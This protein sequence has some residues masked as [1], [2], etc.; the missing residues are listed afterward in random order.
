MRK[1]LFAI[2]FVVF[3]ANAADPTTADLDALRQ[4]A[5]RGDADAQY[6]F[7]ILYEFGF[8]F[9]DNKT[10]AYVWYSRAAE[11][12]HPAAAR[13]RDGLKDQL[14]SAEWER[15]QAQLKVDT[16]VSVPTAAAR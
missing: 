11:Q 4:S 10:S 8:H 7:G 15:A 9:P 1:L 13:R 3:A 16:P 6:E 12:G 14:S 2:F 5:E